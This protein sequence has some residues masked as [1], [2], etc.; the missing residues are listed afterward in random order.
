MNL[1]KKNYIKKGLLVY[2]SQKQFLQ[3][4]ACAFCLINVCI[5]DM[6]IVLNL[7]TTVPKLLVRV[8][9]FL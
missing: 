6:V 4:V 3:E 1:W 7:L 2:Y 9:A 8:T 5:V